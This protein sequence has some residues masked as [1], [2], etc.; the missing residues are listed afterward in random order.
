MENSTPSGGT[1]QL[2]PTQVD[3]PSDHAK[4]RDR[5]DRYPALSEDRFQSLGL[6]IQTQAHYRVMACC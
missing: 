6:L 3:G 4:P 1:L 5:E 2:T